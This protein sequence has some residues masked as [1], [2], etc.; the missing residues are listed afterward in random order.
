MGNAQ[1]SSWKDSSGRKN[2]P[3]GYRFGDFTRS[4]LRKAV[5]PLRSML[6]AEN[7]D[8]GGG[9]KNT[10]GPAAPPPLFRSFDEILERSG[11]AIRVGIG[12]EEALEQKVWLALFNAC[13]ACGV[14]A[15][16]GGILTLDDV[17]DREGYVYLG[18]PALATLEAGLRSVG[19]QG[20][21]LS[22]GTVVRRDQLRARSEAATLL[23]EMFGLIERLELAQSPG[24][25]VQLDEQGLALLRAKVVRPFSDEC[26]FRFASKCVCRILYNHWPQVIHASGDFRTCPDPSVEV[27]ANQVIRCIIPFN[28]PLMLF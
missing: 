8:S 10:S 22:D 6:A 27:L 15:L 16:R 4:V 9:R 3:E 19:R 20:L 25:G 14:G 2:G 5:A 13:F 24:Q 11:A 21:V 1:S 7:D 18:L 17:E 12:A 26:H 23:D 28:P